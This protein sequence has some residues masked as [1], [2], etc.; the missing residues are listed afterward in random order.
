MS[1]ARYAILEERGIL[2]ISGADR[3]EFLQGL[4][5]ND[6]RKLG[7]GRALYAALLTP[8]GK[9]LHDFFLAEAGET[10][11]LDGENA[12]LPDLL[13]R[14]S[15]YKL[16]S[17]V[18]IADASDRY[19]V[20][21]AFGEGSGSKLG[22]AGERGSAVGFGGGV[23]F[24]DPRL[25]SLGE[26]LILPRASGEAALAA[27]GLARADGA[28][29]DRLRL[30]AGVPDGSRDLPVEKA[31]LL[32]AGFD[33]LGGIDWEKGC[34]MG[35]ELT[36]RT[37]YRALIKKR[38]LPVRVEGALPEPGTPVMIDGAEAGEIRSGRGDRALAL[39]RLEAIEDSGRTGIPLTA[40][41]ARITP[42]KPEWVRY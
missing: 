40:G 31:I 10:I 22:L 13:R 33:E 8:Q 12:R 38:L 42:I 35:Q 15:L 14:L 6:T 30:E 39:L 26:R 27:G 25:A 18:S 4:V 9:Y 28:V 2:A 21:A 29:Y 5:S 37:K 23:A 34:Y 36:A 1:E 24:V 17:K 11:L 19:L 7:P 32:E 41:G 3:R 20:A 16:R